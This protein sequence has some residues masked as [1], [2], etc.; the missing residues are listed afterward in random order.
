VYDDSSPEDGPAGN[1]AVP[2]ARGGEQ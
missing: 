2:T 1:G